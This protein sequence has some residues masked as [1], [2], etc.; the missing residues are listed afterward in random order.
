[1]A[2]NSMVPFT[3]FV[4]GNIGSGKTTFLNHFKQFDDVCL[5]TEPVEQWRN[6]KGINLLDLM[7]K[8]PDRFA[9]TF[10]NY[11]TLTMLKLHIKKTEKPVKLMERSMYSARYC[12][13]EKMLSTGTLHEG[14]YNVLQEWYEFIHEQHHVQ[15]DLIVYLRT[16]P[17]IVFDRMKK[18]ARSEESC[19]P[20]EYLKDLHELHENWLM[21]GQ[22]YRP[23][24]VLVL[25]A[26]LELDDI[27][28]EYK[29]SELSVLKPILIENTNH[30][31][32]ASPSKRT[33]RE[34]Y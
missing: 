23:A 34:L 4:E 16:S 6:L 29:R 25:D 2:S 18:R 20:L 5:L 9:M 8:N 21:N 11:V 12:F 13:V 33:E 26:N 30:R 24:P 1:M 15:C 7:Y 31:I 19:V 32:T 28:S 27:G 14:M 10:Q 22:F 17:E 3:V